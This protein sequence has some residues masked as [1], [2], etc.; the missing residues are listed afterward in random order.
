MA[1]E[2]KCFYSIF[3]ECFCLVQFILSNTKISILIALVS[4]KVTYRNYL[5]PIWYKDTS[6][7]KTPIV[8]NKKMNWILWCAK[9]TKDSNSS[10]WGICCFVDCK[11]VSHAEQLYGILKSASAVL[12]HINEFAYCWCKFI[13]MSADEWLRQQ[14]SLC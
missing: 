4:I 10:L 8:Q 3:N 13:N 12:A 2:S 11:D 14:F 9:I 5:N 6:Y 7:Y 1:H